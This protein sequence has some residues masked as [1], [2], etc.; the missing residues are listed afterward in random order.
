MGGENG[1]ILAKGTKLQQHMM[2]KF[3]ISNVLCG[4]YSSKTVIKYL[5]F[6]KRVGLKCSYQKKSKKEGRKEGK[7]KK[8]NGNYIK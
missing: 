4:N 7:K 6:A 8:E 2:K 3:W 5:I 1:E